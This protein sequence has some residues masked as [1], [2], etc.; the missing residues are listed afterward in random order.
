LACLETRSDLSRPIP[1]PFSET[2]NISTLDMKV[3]TD[4]NNNMA[5]GPDNVN[6]SN[7]NEDSS[8]EPDNV[9]ASTAQKDSSSDNKSTSS[10][11]SGEAVVP[12]PSNVQ[13]VNAPTLNVQTVNVPTSTV[14][15]ANVSTLTVV[16]VY[17][18]PFRPVT[19]T[20]NNDDAK[21]LVVPNA[22]LHF[23]TVDAA[24]G[25]GLLGRQAI[26]IEND[27]VAVVKIAANSQVWVNKLVSAFTVDYLSTPEDTTKNSSAQQEWFTR[28]Q[29]QAYAT[30]VTII[31]GKD[32]KHLEKSCWFLLKAVLNAHELGIVDAGGNLTASKTKCSERLAFIV[33]IVEKYALVRLDV[34]RAWHV[35]EIAANPEAFIRRKLVNCWNNSHRAEK[36]KEEK[37]KKEGQKV[38][39][40]KR[41]AG[42]SVEEDEES[43]VQ[44]P[45]KAKRARKS[46]ADAADDGAKNDDKSNK[47]KSTTKTTTKHPRSA[48]TPDSDDKELTPTK[49]STTLKANAPSGAAVKDHAGDAVDD[50]DE[51]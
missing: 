8:S 16:P 40:T 32:S 50:M 31:N 49:R 5:A 35:D 18:R 24:I 37:A 12:S 10:V 14:Q 13:T 23:N 42:K 17:T 43:E 1:K 21:R 3:K 9:T 38:A 34:L 26:T 25:D 27:D 33:S 41:K 29:K 19:A 11:E 51:D 44:T 28:W 20:A 7:A 2:L 46:K 48:L 39:G 4:N 30:L 47:S 36:A 15:T 6:T 45:V 22:T